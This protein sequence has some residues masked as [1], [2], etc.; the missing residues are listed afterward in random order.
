MTNSREQWRT[1]AVFSTSGPTMMP[2]VSDSDRIGMSKASQS[3]MKRAALSEPSLSMA[4]PRCIGLLAIMPI[5]PALDADQ[6]GDHAGPNC[7]RS[8]S[9]E[10]SSA[11]VSITLADVVDAQPVLRDRRGAAG[12]GRRRSSR[13]AAPGSSDRYCLATPHRLGL[14]LDHDV[15]DAVG[16]LHARSGRSPRAGRRPGRR[17]RSSPGRPCRCCESPVA[18]ITSQQPSSAALPAKQRPELMPTSGTSAGQPAPELEAAAS[19]PAALGVARA[20]RRR[21]R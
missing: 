3:C 14:V 17:P 1:S 2:G 9:T 7:G 16:L 10:P 12:A 11:S 4:P 21:P 19:K 6:G 5:G 15:D 8:S 18:M 13:S 20:A